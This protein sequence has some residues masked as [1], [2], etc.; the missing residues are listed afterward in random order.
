[1][2]PQAG[3]AQA[4]LAAPRTTLALAL[5]A[6]PLHRRAPTDSWQMVTVDDGQTLGDLFEQV[7]VPASTM[8]ALLDA[9]S[10]RKALVRLRPGT[11]IGFDIPA[12][13]QLRALRFDRDDT[14]RVLL[15]LAGD[16]IDEQVIERPTTIRTVVVS[17]EVGK[18]LFWSARRQGLSGRA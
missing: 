18:S 9:T 6:L 5:P 13:G 17:G 3:T 12:E 11:V 16:R 7:G 4:S 8:H 1:S 2:A 14:H 15:T 10:E